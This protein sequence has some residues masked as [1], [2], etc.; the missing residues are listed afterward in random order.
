MSKAE[1]AF[2]S[3]ILAFGVV[4]LDGSLKL[5]YYVEEV[6][7]PGFLPL[8]LSLGI[9]A[10]GLVLTVRGMRLGKYRIENVE[11]P[12]AV[13]RWRIAIILAALGLVLIMLD[14][15][16]FLASVALFVAIATFGLGTR[17][18]REL[19]PVPILAAAVLYAIFALWLKVPL[20]KGILSF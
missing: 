1:T 6:P 19:I 17:S 14:T 13:G 15:L 5:P 16:G 9:I 4:L 10:M 8:W 18:W 7:G 20:P 12:D 3:G 11:W 2:G